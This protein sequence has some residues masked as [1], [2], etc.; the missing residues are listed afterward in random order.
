MLGTRCK[1]I[2][3]IANAPHITTVTINAPAGLLVGDTA[4][5][6]AIAV[7]DDGRERPGWPRK[8]SSSN[9]SM[10]SIDGNS[11]MRALSGGGAATLV[12]GLPAAQISWFL[13]SA[14]TVRR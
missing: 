11:L 9:P 3:E 7:A 12:F 8:W 14:S 4:T 5:A 2:A 10:L 6:V 13:C 1:A